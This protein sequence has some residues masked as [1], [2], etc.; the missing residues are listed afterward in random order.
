V[1]MVFC[2]GDLLIREWVKG[3]GKAAM[4]NNEDVEVEEHHGSAELS[5]KGTLATRKYQARSL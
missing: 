4:S 3:T 2:W 5:Q 1:S